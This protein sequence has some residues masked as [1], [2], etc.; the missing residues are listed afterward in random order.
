[1]KYREYRKVLTNQ[2]ITNDGNFS[3]NL[4]SFLKANPDIKIIETIVHKPYHVTIIY[5]EMV[6]VKTGTNDK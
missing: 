5:Q 2:H 6:E 1:M 4:E 3:R